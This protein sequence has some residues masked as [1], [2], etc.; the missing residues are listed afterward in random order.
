MGNGVVALGDSLTPLSWHLRTNLGTE[1]TSM[2]VCMVITYSKG[3]DQP[4]KVAN[5]ACSQLNREREYVP[6]PVR[7]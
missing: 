1:D 3:N 4:G 2:Y 7:A 5:P 6:V